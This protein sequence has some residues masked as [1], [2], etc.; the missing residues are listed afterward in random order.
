MHS[1][2]VLFGVGLALLALPGLATA[3]PPVFGGQRVPQLAAQADAC[4][5]LFGDQQVR[6]HNSARRAHTLDWVDEDEDGVTVAHTNGRWKEPVRLRVRGVQLVSLR[7]K[8]AVV[9]ISPTLAA[10]AGCQPGNYE[11]QVDDALTANTRVLAVLN[12][13]VLVEHRG[14]LGF[15]AIRGTDSPRWLLAWRMNGE[16]RPSPVY[17]L[18]RSP[19]YY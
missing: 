16:V 3:A 17:L 10:A 4:P 11:V 12:S 5:A 15:I 7:S 18:S 6:S 8:R 1:N 14:R 9:Q 19:I 13:S 2:R